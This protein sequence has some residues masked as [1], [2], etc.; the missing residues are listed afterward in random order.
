MEAEKSF[1]QIPTIFCIGG[2]CGVVEITFPT[3][4]PKIGAL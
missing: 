4:A 3:N 2:S 1:L